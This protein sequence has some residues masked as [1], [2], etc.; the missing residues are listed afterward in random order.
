MNTTIMRIII[1]LL[2]SIGLLFLFLLPDILAIGN[3]I[4]ASAGLYPQ[5]LRLSGGVMTGLLSTFLM[6]RYERKINSTKRV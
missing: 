6:R 5:W 4:P 1:G 2:V 3:R